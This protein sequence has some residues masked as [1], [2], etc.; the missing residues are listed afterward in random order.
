MFVVILLFVGCSVSSKKDVNVV[1]S[2]EFK[3][4]IYGNCI[5]TLNIDESLNMI[6]YDSCNC[7]DVG[8]TVLFINKRTGK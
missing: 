7:Y 5:F 3:S 2:K 8:D 6:L 1:T 4:T